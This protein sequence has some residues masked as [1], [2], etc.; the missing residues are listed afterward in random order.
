ML[1]LAASYRV[2]DSKHAWAPRMAQNR[3]TP[4]TLLS[5]TIM[6]LTRTIGEEIIQVVLKTKTECDC[7]L[8]LLRDTRN[9]H[10]QRLQ[11]E[12]VCM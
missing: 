8:C 10:D 5:F 1:H 12:R 4:M 9:E 3:T 11:G 6:C 7:C 2:S